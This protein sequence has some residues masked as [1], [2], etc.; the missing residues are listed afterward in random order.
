MSRTRIDHLRGKTLR[1]VGQ[2]L[3]GGR[4][5]E[6]V[7]H[8][9]LLFLYSSRRI[10]LVVKINGLRLDLKRLRYTRANGRHVSRTD[11]WYQ[12][13]IHPLRN[14]GFRPRPRLVNRVT[15]CLSVV[16]GNMLSRLLT[17]NS[18]LTVI[19]TTD[20]LY[21]VVEL[22]NALRARPRRQHFHEG[23]TLRQRTR[24]NYRLLPNNGN[25]RLIRR[26]LFIHF[27]SNH[28]RH[29]SLPLRNKLFQ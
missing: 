23:L 27:N 6:H 19:L 29:V 14:I 11:L 3:W 24:K 2:R 28:R 15:N 21:P 4:P 16:T 8:S 26:R 22:M 25:S 13:R 18:V 5:Y 1:G 10:E 7:T 20:L 9:N 12:R 17:T